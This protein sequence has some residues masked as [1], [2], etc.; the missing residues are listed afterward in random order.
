M[1]EQ[2]EPVGRSAIVWA[3]KG[4]S[5]ITSCLIPNGQIFLAEGVSLCLP[6][7]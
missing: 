4:S 5:G 2:S 6:L 1:S 3:D 7:A